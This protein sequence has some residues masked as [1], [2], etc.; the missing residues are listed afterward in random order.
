MI[1]DILDPLK[2]IRP[3]LQENPSTRFKQGIWG[4]NPKVFSV[5]IITAEN[6]EGNEVSGKENEILR[7]KMKSYL[8]NGY[9]SYV[10]MT[11]GFYGVKEHPVMV[12]NISLKEVKAMADTFNQK[13][14]IFAQKEKVATDPRGIENPNYPLGWVFSMFEKYK[15]NNH[16]DVR[17]NYDYKVV[18]SSGVIRTNQDF[19]DFYSQQKNWKFKI[20]FETFNDFEGSDPTDTDRSTA[21]WENTIENWYGSLYQ[22][23]EAKEELIEHLNEINERIAYGGFSDAYRKRGSLMKYRAKSK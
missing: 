9:F 22:L 1:E 2:L 3:R 20:P 19:T 8:R 17:K 14:F 12:F 11:K 21:R 13:A 16:P 5:A 6:P 10:Q 7:K 4:T 23:K 18:D 15:A